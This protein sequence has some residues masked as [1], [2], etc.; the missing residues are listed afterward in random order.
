LVGGQTYFDLSGMTDPIRFE[1]HTKAN[2]DGFVQPP[3]LGSE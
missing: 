3:E 1:M 2:S